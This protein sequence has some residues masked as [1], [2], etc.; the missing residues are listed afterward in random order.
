MKKKL[1]AQG[2][3]VRS[4]DGIG[5]SEVKAGNV[6]NDLSAVAY[7]AGV[8]VAVGYQHL[9]TSLAVWDGRRGRRLGNRGPGPIV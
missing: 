7:G 9:I 4:T 2:T 1:T 8:F 6:T 3:I 5:W